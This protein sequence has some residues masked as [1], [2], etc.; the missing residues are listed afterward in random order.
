MINIGR[1]K[2]QRSLMSAVILAALG[3]SLQAAYAADTDT[4]TETKTTKEA[5][6]KSGHKKHK[7]AKKC[8]KK[9]KTSETESSTPQ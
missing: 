7:T 8:E 4:T 2:M 5:T 9:E 6:T 1:N 3:V